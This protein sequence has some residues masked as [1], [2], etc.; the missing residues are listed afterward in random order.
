MIEAWH[1]EIIPFF[2][3]GDPVPESYVAWHDWAEVQHRGGL[4]QT[5]CEH[6]KWLYPQ[7]QCDHQIRL[8]AS[9]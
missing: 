9:R 6:G 1:I 4:R 7:E 2:K 8:E 5:R 3:V